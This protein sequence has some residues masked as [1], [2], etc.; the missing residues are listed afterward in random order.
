VLG[1]DGR[2]PQPPG[3]GR[4]LALAASVFALAI[5]GALVAAAFFAARQ[6]L[7]IGL[8]SR[9]SLRALAAAEAGLNATIADMSGGMPD[10]MAVGDS[11]PFSGSLGSGAGGA[12]SGT[13]LRLNGELF[14]IQAIGSDPTGWA[15]RRLAVLVRLQAAER[16]I[17]AALTTAGPVQ[18]RGS[19]RLDGID[20]DPPGWE[21]PARVPDT[22]PDVAPTGEDL[23]WDAL[24]AMA[25]KTYP[26]GEV[27]LLGTLAPVGTA[28]ICDAAS[29]DNWGEPRRPAAV[30]G[31]AG[32]YPI[33]YSAGN[34]RISGGVGQGLLLVAG[35]LEISGGAEF[36]GPVVVRGTLRMIGTGGHLVGGV[37]A[38][39]ADLASGGAAS[40]TGITYSSCAVS[41]VLRQ[42]PGLR[43][44][45]ERSWAELPWG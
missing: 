3:A 6:E 32:Y 1:R 18:V 9:A 40:S 28:T 13:V 15:R 7:R 20:M 27:G 2:A 25:A 33:I 14:L 4:G 12:Y 17:M 37:E 39:A 22:V 10:P 41:R 5:I 38:G 34:L 30:A 44:I 36:Y 29:A 24:V 43:R 21:C 8:N 23:D 26:A 35:D 16:P 45:R 31:C 19:A 11:V 42:N